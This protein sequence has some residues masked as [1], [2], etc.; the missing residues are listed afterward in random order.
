M[1]PA[2]SAPLSKPSGAVL[3]LVTVWI[4]IPVLVQVTVAP[5]V[6]EMQGGSK[7]KS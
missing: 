1:P 6:T 7:P 2:P 3:S 5:A 4:G